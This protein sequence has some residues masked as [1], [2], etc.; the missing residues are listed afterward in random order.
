MRERI[1]SLKI[2][3]SVARK[4]R[5][6]ERSYLKTFKYGGMTGILGAVCCAFGM[7]GGIGFVISALATLPLILATLMSITTG[8]FSYF[9]T[10]ILL[11]VLQPS[12]AY[13]YLLTQGI[14]GLG[15]GI[16]FQVFKKSISTILFSGFFLFLGILFIL[17]VTK[18]TVLGPDVGTNLSWNISA[19]ILLFSI[20]YSA[21]WVVGVTTF[22]NKFSNFNLTK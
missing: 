15:M 19:M 16:G 2:D 20:V 7:L 6:K 1:F 14:L 21:I 11:C 9:I 4:W 22:L 13:V 12:E 17:G 5:L 10:F 3:T 8:V 18:F